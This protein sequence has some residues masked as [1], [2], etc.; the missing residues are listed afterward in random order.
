MNMPA[1]VLSS[2]ATLRHRVHQMQAILYVTGQMDVTFQRRGSTPSLLTTL[3][4]RSINCLG[5]LKLPLNPLSEPT[6]LICLMHAQSMEVIAGSYVI[7]E[8]I[9]KTLIAAAINGSA[10]ACVDF[11]L[12]D[13]RGVVWGYLRG[14]IPTESVRPYIHRKNY[15]K[16]RKPKRP[17]FDDGLTLCMMHTGQDALLRWSSPREFSPRQIYF[18]LIDA[19]TGVYIQSLRG[20]SH[21]PNTGTFTWVVDVPFLSNQQRFRACYLIMTDCA[22]V[23]DKSLPVL[24]QSNT[25]FVL[26][27]LTLCE[28]EFA[29]ASFCRINHLDMQH[30]SQGFLVGRNFRVENRT[31]RVIHNLRR[32]LPF[33]YRY[34]DVVH[35]HGQCVLASGSRLIS[36]KYTDFTEGYQAESSDRKAVS[37][38]QVLQ[39]Q[40][41]QIA[42]MPSSPDGVQEARVDIYKSVS[43]RLPVI[44]NFSIDYDPYWWIQSPDIRMLMFNMMPYNPWEICS[45]GFFSSLMPWNTQTYDETCSRYFIYNLSDDT[46]EIERFWVYVIWPSILT[47]TDIL[48]IPF[49]SMLGLSIF[50]AILLHGHLLHEFRRHRDIGL[51]SSILADIVFAEDKLGFFFGLEYPLMP[52]TSTVLAGVV[53][54]TGY[55]V[56]SPFLRSIVNIPYDPFYWL[57]MAFWFITF[58]ATNSLIFIAINWLIVAGLV[59]TSQ[60]APIAVMIASIAFVCYSI[61]GSFNYAR[62]TIY[63][64]ITMNLAKLIGVSLDYW[65]DND[66]PFDDLEDDSKAHEDHQNVIATTIRRRE[67]WEKHRAVHSNITH[68]H[69]AV[70]RP[71]RRR[72]SMR[73]I[74]ALA[75]NEVNASFT[76]PQLTAREVTIPK[77]RTRRHE[78]RW[79]IQVV[80]AP[81]GSE[82]TVSPSG[83]VSGLDG[84]FQ[85]GGRLV[86][87]AEA[88]AKA[89]RIATLLDT[90]EV[91][92]VHGGSVQLGNDDQ[93]YKFARWSLAD[94]HPGQTLSFD[95]ALV[96]Y[97]KYP[98][99]AALTPVEKV[100]LIFDYFDLNQDGTWSKDEYQR[101]VT[102]CD[103]EKDTAGV[104]FALDELLNF[105]IAEAAGCKC[106]DV[107][108]VYLHMPE[109]ID[110]DYVKIFPTN[111][112]D[113]EFDGFSIDGF[114]VNNLSD[115]H[116]SD[117]DVESLEAHEVSTSDYGEPYTESMSEE[118]SKF[119][120]QSCDDGDLKTKHN[121][122]KFED[123]S[124]DQSSIDE[125]EGKVDLEAELRNNFNA[126]K[127]H[128]IFKRTAEKGDNR[129]ISQMVDN[130]AILAENICATRTRL[131]VPVFGKSVG[132]VCRSPNDVAP[133]QGEGFIRA[134]LIL[135]QNLQTYLKAE[136]WKL[137]QELTHISSITSGVSNFYDTFIIDRV[138]F[139][140]RTILKPNVELTS[141]DVHSMNSPELTKFPPK[142]TFHLLR[143]LAN[144][145]ITND[146]VLRTLCQLSGV[147]GHHE[148]VVQVS[149]VTILLRDCGLITAA[150]CDIKEYT[151][152]LPVSA[153]IKSWKDVLDSSGVKINQA[154]GSIRLVLPASAMCQDFL[155]SV[156]ETV[157]AGGSF[158]PDDAVA[159]I[160]YIGERFLWLESFFFLVRLLGICLQLEPLPGVTMEY[161]DVFANTRLSI[162]MGV[163]QHH[164]EEI[165]YQKV[166]E[167]CNMHAVKRV[168]EDLNG[169]THFLPVDLADEAILLLTDNQM[170]FSAATVCLQKLGL[171]APTSFTVSEDLMDTW[172]SLGISPNAPNL[173]SIKSSNEQQADHFDWTV[174]YMETSTN[175]EL[176]GE[177]MKLTTGS[178]GFVTKSQMIEFARC[179]SEK[180]LP[181]AI[182]LG[183]RHDIESPLLTL[184][185]SPGGGRNKDP[186]FE[187]LLSGD[188]VEGNIP[189]GSQESGATTEIQR[190]VPNPKGFVTFEMFHRIL[191]KTRIAFSRKHTQ[192]LWSLICAQNSDEV[193]SVL[194]IDLVPGELCK[195]IL[196][197]RTSNG[198][199]WTESD[200]IN[201][202]VSFGGCLTFNMFK[203]FLHLLEF[204][205]NESGMRT[206]W[207]RI[208][209]GTLDVSSYLYL[210]LEK[211][212]TVK[213]S[214]GT[215]ARGMNPFQGKMVSVRQV[216]KRLPKV[217][218]TGLWPACVTS[219]LSL[220]LESQFSKK[221]ISDIMQKLPSELFN[222]YGLLKPKGIITVLRNLQGEGMTY[223]TL[224]K[225]VADMRVNLPRSSIRRMFSLMDSNHDMSL[226]IDELV[227]GFSILF[228]HFIPGLIVDSLGCSVGRQIHVILLTLLY[229]LVFFAFIAFS[230]Q[231][232]SSTNGSAGSIIQSLLALAGAISLQ[233]GARKDQAVVERELKGRMALLLGD[234]YDIMLEDQD[235]QLQHFAQRL[236]IEKE[237]NADDFGSRP[238]EIRYLIPKKFIGTTRE[239]EHSMIFRPGDT[240]RLDPI[241]VG[242]IDTSK[243]VWM[244][245]PT[246]PSVFG[247][248]FNCASGT[249]SGTIPSAFDDFTILSYRF[250]ASTPGR[251]V[252]RMSSLMKFSGTVVPNADDLSVY[253]Y[254][255]FSFLI[256]CRSLG[257]QTKTR[258][259]FKLV[260]EQV[261]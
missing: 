257:G 124:D 114:S 11:P 145:R 87:L 42:S 130:K 76:E 66:M 148:R 142:T 214:A 185:D 58:F 80:V 56:A 8:H 129:Y 227:G 93:G 37:I 123:Q 240:V 143:L 3:V 60:F 101:W 70:A 199:P 107:Y 209:K 49:A 221:E 50:A 186:T 251:Q 71:L 249:I 81:P 210:K 102:T 216:G 247:L 252:R 111:R 47:G 14:S 233:S 158:G 172:A 34:T 17:Y 23:R 32:P 28:F 109:K 9:L 168:F 255:K 110:R 261:H 171:D 52:L 208:P 100:G 85:N 235:R 226:D 98:D 40:K 179:V 175:E 31:L 220:H 96:A 187:G 146:T 180:I 54:C 134:L 18:H 20:G 21:I 26:R 189:L 169:N 237:R 63:T 117:V 246:L 181:Q 46:F 177:F 61:V 241:V 69:K 207:S 203:E 141:K 19:D 153:K 41:R 202:I 16:V 174:Y 75:L 191:M 82:F 150:D 94:L 236:E 139:K 138:Q 222:S 90:G 86:S 173:V 200:G 182:S 59:N 6:F 184:R 121:S 48:R 197:P 258:L 38:E 217:L 161:D 204:E 72:K 22:F 188:H 242:K 212:G 151:N 115:S 238:M 219:L 120:D 45:S 73:A 24:A 10:D 12:L 122:I 224:E 7:T 74:D 244:I 248:S 250:P 201:A 105:E 119:S 132:L 125:R 140:A 67:Q 166:I 195:I 57:L 108:S 92:M 84:E 165:M 27:T 88:I 1:S 167:R 13:P 157:V 183:R 35:S 149:V 65:F 159:C 106:R 229:S 193:Q 152:V 228:S 83:V 78:I 133:F 68:S 135:Q 39:Q 232:F 89:D 163:S 155:G 260:P 170:N 97:P 116:G 99:V 64:F 259:T 53:I 5:E 160:R 196:Q 144:Y 95:L 55:T 30:V 43:A 245:E 147:A 194:S 231:S 29:Y 44:L 162:P 25:F 15:I 218:L 113:N 62:E 79:R 4:Q 127:L 253:F 256:T 128:A 154:T 215:D 206:I 126:R 205:V 36:L 198:V 112:V 230:F 2:K 33:E 137:N 176:F 51:D 213:I 104:S 211:E 164:V 156:I 223:A 225:V 239:N 131:L 118:D 243:L 103:R 192:L 91:G 77:K 234:N 178:S 254:K 190:P 136:L